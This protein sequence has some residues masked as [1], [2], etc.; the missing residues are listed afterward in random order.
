MGMIINF[1]LFACGVIGCIMGLGSRTNEKNNKLTRRYFLAQGFCLFLWCGG[2]A[3]M[4]AC[5]NETYALVFRNM[6]L[7]GV[8]CF[9]TAE[10]YYFVFATGVMPRMRK[11]FLALIT[12]VSMLDF[13]LFSAKINI[14]FFRAQGR[15]C[16]YGVNGF[17]RYFHSALLALFFVFLLSVAILWSRRIELKREKNIIMALVWSNSLTLIFSIP[18]TFLPAMDLPSFPTSGYGAFLTY[19]VSYYV[20]IR[21]NTFDISQQNLGNYIY[22]Y[23][24]SPVLIFDYRGQL[25]MLNDY[26][27]DYFNIAAAKGKH[28]YDIF[29][30]SHNDCGVLFDELNLQKAR[31]CKL[32]TLDSR[33]ICALSFTAVEDRYEEPYC[34]ICMCYDLSKES[35]IMSELMTVKQQLEHQLQKKS[36][37]V[38]RMNLLTITTIANTIDARDEYTKGHSVRVAQYCEIFANELGWREGRVQNLKYM[39]LLHDIGKIGVPDSVLNKPGKLTDMEYRMVQ[40]HTVIGAE[41]VKDIEMIEGLNDGVRWHHERWDGKGYPDGLKGEQIPIVAR[42]I[43]IA[44][45]YDAMSSNRVYR[46]RLSADE[47]RKELMDGRGTQF[48]PDILDI[49]VRMVDENRLTP[50]DEGDNSETFE[51]ESNILFGRIMDNYGNFDTE[52]DYL[53][54]IWSRKTG[55]KLISDEMKTHGGC[56]VFLDMDNLKK[57]NDIHGHIAGDKA[58]QTTAKVM[59]DQGE[60]FISARMGGD[61]FL[62]F[63]PD[64]DKDRAAA[65]IESVF[66][67]FQ[68]VRENT[69]FMRETSLSAGMYVC[70][71]GC[72]LSEAMERADKAL[73]HVKQNGKGGY[74]FYEDKK[75]AESGDSRV[76]LDRLMTALRLQGEYGGAFNVE[77]REFAGIYN[78]ISSIVNRYDYAMTLLLVTICPSGEEELPAEDQETA[79]FCMEKAISE[80]LRSVDVCTRFSST[81]LLLILTDAEEKQVPLI[82]DRVLERFLRIYAKDNVNVTYDTAQYR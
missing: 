23:V 75:A 52:K 37:Q 2:Y 22:R 13:I 58:L 46:G 51:K 16:Y 55:E 49:F 60:G 82:T 7:L 39:A 54:G 19:V 27:S 62:L 8:I 28:L 6:G 59:E 76:D 36:R 70:S 21:L 73:Y 26:A 79:V 47:I 57:V 41:I 14:E 65:N 5:E 1:S 61:E 30:I 11:A 78:Y 44:D 66:M 56:L 74:Y 68:R 20:V 77:Y 63:M 64:A 10:V 35:E 38:E 45:S 33:K 69:Q 9:L 32:L 67:S 42:I 71:R 3:L 53:T 12:I 50:Y 43:A 25:I 17:A 72:S 15:M 34:Y 29:Q 4:G 18:D 48:A 81:Q 24:K 31:N 80:A 40:K